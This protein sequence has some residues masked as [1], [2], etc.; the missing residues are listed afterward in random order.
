EAKA[1]AAAD[2]FSSRLGET[3]KERRSRESL[4]RLLGDE[5]AAG[6][7]RGFDSLTEPG[8]SPSDAP[9]GAAGLF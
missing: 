2:F 7:A 8:S 6:A 1:L 9:Q 5:A 4:D 3:E